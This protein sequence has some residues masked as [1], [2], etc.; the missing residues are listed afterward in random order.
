ME[1]MTLSFSQR[2]SVRW[3]S[4]PNRCIHVDVSFIVEPVCHVFL[5]QHHLLFLASGVW[6]TSNLHGK[7]A[8]V[9][10]SRGGQEGRAD[11]FCPADPRHPSQRGRWLPLPFSRNC[12]SSWRK[13]V[14]R[15]FTF[16]V[17]PKHN[18]LFCINAH[19][20]NTEINTI[21]VLNL[22]I[23]WRSFFSEA[24]QLIFYGMDYQFVTFRTCACHL[25]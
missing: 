16:A 4:T 8:L 7:D 17:K 20:S 23:I 24:M 21:Q 18:F 22:Q 15:C 1:L 6:K 14:Q 13:L 3:S 19:L 9:S 2:P 10:F 25:M 12:K 5:A 11:R